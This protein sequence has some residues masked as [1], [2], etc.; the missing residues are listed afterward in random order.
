MV[1]KRALAHWRLLS[2]VVVGVLLAC[3][4]MAGTVIYFE[5]LRELALRNTLDTQPENELNLVLKAERGPTTRT[6]RSKVSNTVDASV[7]TWL[8][9]FIQDRYTAGRSATFFVSTPGLEAEAGAGNLRAYFAYTPSFG[10]LTTLTSGAMPRDEALN[11][12]GEPL[13]IEALVPEHLAREAGVSV[14]DR[15]SVIP[16]WDDTFRRATVI[17]SGTFVENDRSHPFWNA[18]DKV[19]SAATGSSFVTYPF[20]ISETAFFDSL[21]A[22][23]RRMDSTYVWVL[24][25]DSGALRSHNTAIAQQGI[26]I[27]DQTLRAQLFSYR[28]FT[29]LDSVL[30]NYDQ[31]IFFTKLPMIIVLILI[32]VVILYYVL[33]LSALLVEQQRG[34]IVLL[35]SRGAGPVHLLTVFALEGGTIALL[36]ALLGPVI[37]AAA[38]SVAGYTPAFSD[39]TGGSALITHVSSMSYAL[40]GLGGLFSFGALMLPA[41]GIARSTVAQQRQDAAR[42]VSQPFFQRYYLD[43][44]LL[45]FSIFLFRQLTEQGSFV[46]RQLF[47]ENTVNQI[48]LAVPALTLLAGAL[49][50]LRLFP[51]LMGLISRLFSRWMPA[52]LTFAVW[53]MARNPT[54]YAR[55]TLLLILTAGLGIFAASFGATLARNFEERALYTSGGNVRLEA[56]NVTI[57]GKTEPIG[58]GYEQAPGVDAAALAYRGSGYDASKLTGLDFDAFS[59][60]ANSAAGFVWARDDFAREPIPDLLRMLPSRTMPQGIPIPDDAVSLGISLKA[61]RPQPSVVVLIRVKDANERWFTYR[62]GALETAN[63]QTLESRL[64]RLDPSRIRLQRLEPTYPLQ[65]MS[66]AVQ[67]SD[68]QRG[69]LAG[70]LFIDEVF[71]RAEDG[72]IT[73]VEPFDSIEGWN[74]LMVSPSS[75]TDAVTE[76][77][78]GMDGSGAAQFVWFEGPALTARG[79]YSGPLLEP[80]PVLVSSKF[81][82]DTGHS[83]NETLDMVIASQR[84]NTRITGVFDYFPSL[85]TEN[86]LYVITD[87]G[88]LLAYA[89]IDPSD[90]ELKPNE[91]WL[92]TSLTGAE[93]AQFVEDVSRKPFVAPIKF[94]SEQLQAQHRVDPLT[95][96]GWRSLLFIAFGA[97][98]IL[99]CVGF[100]VH[101]YV[102]F[103]NRRI[104]FALLRTVGLSTRQLIAIVFVEQALV[105]AAGI[106][107]GTWMGGQLG[108]IIMPFLSTDDSGSQVLPPFVLE[109]NWPVLLITY[110]IMIGIFSLITIG[111]IIFARRV[112]VARTLRL[113]EL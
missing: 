80:L 39:L 111:V 6:E 15:F 5:S 19:L 42:P 26:Q 99:S 106:A 54:H 30:G 76:T 110:G 31:R 44:L 78:N 17:V 28:Q 104:Q 40:S 74:T 87:L 57:T 103:R 22:S 46:A 65:L 97:V 27:L 102:S 16:Y 108:T 58:P 29:S 34:E 88:S 2:A 25:V 47:G 9:W 72:S 14:G 24:D 12:P 33:T 23:F 45:V 92:T 79:I 20:Y 109:V 38:V 84:I 67:Q 90:A 53:S 96:A 61:D 36:G 7:N 85:D 75:A 56:M 77:S 59:V 51:I 41:I 82:K 113:G 98:L 4:I 1:I 49:V 91:V 83:E 73:V 95:R 11:V 10:D 8:G 32:A 55:L 50:L 21:A 13:I 18:D 86:E 35:R 71:T 101:A 68:V 48:L 81:L 43:I 100:I 105:V 89:N 60:D 69:M 63:W 112:S 52:S 107:L 3:A 93:R 94:D 37:A 70:A 66:V 62:M 64:S